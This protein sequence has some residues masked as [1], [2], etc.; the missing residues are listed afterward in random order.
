[1][2][3][4]LPKSAASKLVYVSGFESA[5]SEM[6]L[7]RLKPWANAEKPILSIQYSNYRSR[8]NEFLACGNGIGPLVTRPLSEGCEARLVGT[9]RHLVLFEV[10]P[11]EGAGTV[12]NARAAPLR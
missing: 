5:T 11:A 1:M 4:Y 7:D 12:G 2:N 3:Y 9:A 6:L 10:R 8:L